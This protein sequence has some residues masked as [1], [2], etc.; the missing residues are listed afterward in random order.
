VQVVAAA[1]GVERVLL[2]VEGELALGDAVGVQ[3][4]DRAEVG[5]GL[6]VELWLQRAVAQHDVGHVAVAVGHVEFGEVAA[7]VGDLRDESVAVVRVYRSTDSPSLVLPNAARVTADVVRGEDVDRCR[8]L[9]GQ[10]IDQS[11]GG[12]ADPRRSRPGSGRA[13]PRRGP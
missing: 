13:P 2:A 9:A 3:A 12:L 1:A 6:V 5:A 10:P 7:E 11:V 4:D 8:R